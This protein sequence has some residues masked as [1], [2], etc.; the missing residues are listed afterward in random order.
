MQCY[1]ESENPSACVLLRE[2]Y[3]ECLHH[4]KEVSTYPRP[5]FNLSSPAQHPILRTPLLNLGI[6]LTPLFPHSESPTYRQP[7][8]RLSA[9]N[10][11]DVLRIALKRLTASPKSWPPVRLALHLS[12]LVSLRSMQKGVETSR[13][14]SSPIILWSREFEPLYLDLTGR[15]DTR[16]V[17]LVREMKVGTHLVVRLRPLALPLQELFR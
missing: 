17:L 13:H 10:F 8:M 11:K 2:D 6:L 9:Q 3:L 4:F 12:A 1:A 15:E 5:Y 14:R 7:E 16:T